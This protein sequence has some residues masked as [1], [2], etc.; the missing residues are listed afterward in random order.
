MTTQ[1]QYS[2]IVL[3]TNLQKESENA[4]NWFRSNEMEV[5]PD[6]FQSIIINRLE[7]L[8]NSYELLTDNHNID[9]ENSLKLFGIEIDTKLNVEK[10]AAALCQKAGR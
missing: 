7:K 6:K 8:K 5:N 10:Q 1:L 3:I 4:I 9:S 2:Q